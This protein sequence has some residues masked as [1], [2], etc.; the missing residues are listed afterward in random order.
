M[1]SVFIRLSCCND[2]IYRSSI[3]SCRLLLSSITVTLRQE[4]RRGEHGFFKLNGRERTL[5]RSGGA[6]DYYFV[7]GGRLDPVAVVVD[8]GVN[9]DGAN[10]FG[11]AG[12]GVSGTFEDGLEDIA[13]VTPAEF[14]EAGGV[15]VAINATITDFE[16]AG[17]L[18]RAAPVEEH[19]LDGR[20]KRV[21]A[22]SAI[23][24]VEIQVA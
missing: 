18:L 4:R 8:A 3:L 10:Y 17:D 23:T 15:S 7:G 6:L 19:F 22:D 12:G 21:V 16:A 24:L 14:V 5:L 11:G 20:A 13:E 9:A 2:D 1:N